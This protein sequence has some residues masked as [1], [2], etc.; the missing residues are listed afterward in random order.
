PSTV[1]AVT[2]INAQVDFPGSTLRT[3]SPGVY[4]GSIQVTPTVSGGSNTP[5]AV[6]VTLTVV[7]APSVTFSATSLTFNVQTAPGGVNN[8]T[9]ATIQMTTDSTQSVSFSVF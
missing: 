4:T 9:T 5:L 3:L 2:A 1:P 7:A 8:P 6:P